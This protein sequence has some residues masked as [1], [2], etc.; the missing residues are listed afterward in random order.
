MKLLFVVF[1]VMATLGLLFKHLVNQSKQPTG[2][3]GQLMMKTWNKAYFPMV[4]WSL[5]AMSQPTA[6]VILDVGIGNGL[7]SEYLYRQYPDCQLYGIDISEEAIKETRKRFSQNKACFSVQTIENTSFKDNQFDLICAFQT[8]FHW[9]KLSEAFGEVERI[10]KPEGQLLLACE[11]SKLNIY[12]PDL[13]EGDSFQLF[14]AQFN[15][16]L[17]STSSSGGFVRY[18]VAKVISSHPAAS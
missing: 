1:L 9:E 10:L 7:S 4:Q 5:T 16:R 18:V 14:L 6:P 13:A 17:L 12:L 3:I 11:R 2:V 15:L 8:H